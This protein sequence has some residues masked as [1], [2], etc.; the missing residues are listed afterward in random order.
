M[1]T[2]L[3]LSFPISHTNKRGGGQGAQGPQGADGANGADGAQGPQGAQGAAGAN[4]AGGAQ[5]PQ[6]A[7]GAQG[8]AGANGAGGAQGPQGA[9]GAQGPRGADLTYG[10]Y[11]PI[12]GGVMTGPIIHNGTENVGGA[13]VLRGDGPNSG[14]FFS[15]TKNSQQIVPVNG[16]ITF[17]NSTSGVPV[18]GYFENAIKD[19]QNNVI[20]E[21]Y[22][23]KSGGRII[24]DI[25]INGALGIVNNEMNTYIF[26]INSGGS[27]TINTTETNPL[28]G[29][30]SNANKATSATTVPFTGIPTGT[31]SNTVAVGNHTHKRTIATGTGK[32]YLLGYTT[33]TDVSSSM[34]MYTSS[35]EVYMQNGN[36]YAASDERLKDFAG[37]VDVD[38]DDIKRIPKKYYTWKG[39]DSDKLQIGTSAQELHKIYPEIVSID[40]E[41]THSVAYD[42]LSIIALAAIDKL[43]EENK[44]LKERLKRIEEHLG[45]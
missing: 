28:E 20:T 41:G 27:L 13:I 3:R 38:L 35:I 19:G 42:R 9:D 6:G 1:N 11:L 40:D 43:Y 14:I 22:L 17:L 31:T 10:A 8:A 25:S 23:P 5:G 34:S 24:G 15:N 39:D 45:L 16:N 12:S 37:D 26:G 21:T 29:Y 4:G 7:Q 2:R 36:L 30:V 18:M 44:E 32:Y 33:Q